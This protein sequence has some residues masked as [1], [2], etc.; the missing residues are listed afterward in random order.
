MSFELVYQGE[1]SVIESFQL[2][3]DS[4]PDD[5]TVE[6]DALADEIQGLYQ[7]LNLCRQKMERLAQKAVK[8]SSPANVAVV[9][10]PGGTVEVD[11]D[12]VTIP[13]DWWDHACMDETFQD[14]AIRAWYETGWCLQRKSRRRGKFSLKVAEGWDFHLENLE[15]RG[16]CLVYDGERVE[17]DYE[18]SQ[19]IDQIV[20]LKFPSFPALPDH[21]N[22]EDD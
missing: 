7:Q 4:E 14:H 20:Q 11:D 16:D 22:L 10:S 18:G 19:C 13:D 2:T 6:M 1:C 5:F 21:V 17:N 3:R 8:Y 12:P 15:W 9:F